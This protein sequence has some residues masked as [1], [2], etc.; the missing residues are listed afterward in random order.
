MAGSKV[1]WHGDEALL[2]VDEATDEFLTQ[3]AFQGEGLAKVGATVDTGF[4]RNAIYGMGPNGSN[5]ERAYAEA[6][7]AAVGYRQ[8]LAEEP[9][10]PDRT[11]AVHGA[12]E[13]TI[14]QEERVGFMYRALEQLKRFVAQEVEQAGQ[15]YL[16]D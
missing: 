13:Y 15:E 4:M 2:V 7:D 1:V 3:L 16:G 10:L 8:E 11:A 12:A 9:D 5:R 6:V 14:F